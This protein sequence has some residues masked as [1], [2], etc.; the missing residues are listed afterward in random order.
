MKTI[1]LIGVLDCIL[2]KG[3]NILDVNTIIR[4]DA[5][6]GTGTLTLTVS[7]AVQAG[8]SSTTSV[9]AEVVTQGVGFNVSRTYTVTDSYSVKGK[10][11]YKVILTAYP[12]YK[13]RDFKVYDD[14]CFGSDTYEGNGTD[15]K[16]VGVYFTKKYKKL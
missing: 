12:N 4:R 8:Y 5:A 14:S 13:K 2:K 9:S 10:K 1:R 3:K 11:G 16:P 15:R 6:E 7:D